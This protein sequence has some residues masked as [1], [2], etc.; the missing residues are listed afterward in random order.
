MCIDS[1]RI[2]S[3]CP[4]SP[5]PSPLPYILCLPPSDPSL[6]LALRSLLHPTQARTGDDP[7]RDVRPLA[8]WH[9][10][11]DRTRLRSLRRESRHARRSVRGRGHCDTRGDGDGVGRGGGFPRIGET[12]RKYRIYRAL[13]SEALRVY[14]YFSDGTI[15]QSSV[16]LGRARIEKGRRRIRTEAGEVS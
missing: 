2:I 10:L 6:P 1:P 12:A 13:S 5:P 7:R 9:V 3:T 15:A 16:V 11:L 8:A 4:P 14:F